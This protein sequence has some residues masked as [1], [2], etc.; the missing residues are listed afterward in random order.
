MKV[1]QIEPCDVMSHLMAGKDVC[2]VDFGDQSRLRDAN[3]YSLKTQYMKDIIE[4][5]GNPDNLF[6]EEVQ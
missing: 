3:V 6:F 4:A 5:V 2:C 1:K